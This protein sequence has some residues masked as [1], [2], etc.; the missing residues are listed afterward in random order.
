M[1]PVSPPA[2]IDEAI[3][4]LDELIKQT[5]DGKLDQ[6]FFMRFY[7]SVLALTPVPKIA[8][9]GPI[10]SAPTVASTFYCDE[11]DERDCL[12]TRMTR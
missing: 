11:G 9:E 12:L 3:R 7:Q 8:Y 10:R 1:D 5:K 2:P 6:A 4:R